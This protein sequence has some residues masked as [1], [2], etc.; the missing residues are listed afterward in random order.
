LLLT[1]IQKRSEYPKE[2]PPAVLS[3]IQHISSLIK[4]DADHL[5]VNPQIDTDCSF[6]C[7]SH[8]DECEA[9]RKAADEAR[10]LSIR[11]DLQVAV[12]RVDFYSTGFVARYQ[13]R[14]IF[15]RQ[16]QLSRFENAP[17]YG[18]DKDEDNMIESIL[19]MCV[20]NEDDQNMHRLW[21][22]QAARED[23]L[24]YIPL[25]A[26]SAKAFV[27]NVADFIL[28]LETRRLLNKPLKD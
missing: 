8:A 11:A 7:S 25:R 3:R 18:K 23:P 26:Y 24:T 9:V 10:K 15:L 20:M 2:L 4:R 16:L 5:L 12:D 19:D 17:I 13:L 21:G 14:M 28:D 1:F 22:S 27:V 6:C